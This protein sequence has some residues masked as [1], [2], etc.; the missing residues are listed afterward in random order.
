[1]QA[2]YPVK[3]QAIRSKGRKDRFYALV[4]MALAAA[5]GMEAGELVQWS[6]TDRDTLL[7]RR[8]NPPAKPM[9]GNVAKKRKRA[10][11]K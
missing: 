6:L 8:V 2:I 1:M 7:V 5:I 3:I 11:R 10:S 9:A 4:P